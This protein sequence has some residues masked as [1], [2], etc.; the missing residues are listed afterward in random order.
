MI[1]SI[2]IPIYN[3]SGNISDLISEIEINL[4][5]NNY[6]II[7]ENEMFKDLTFQQYKILKKLSNNDH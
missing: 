1:F 7:V 4:D 3:E 6:E 2:I 5:F